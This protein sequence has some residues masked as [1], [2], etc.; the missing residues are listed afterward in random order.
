MSEKRISPTIDTGI[1]RRI[2][3]DKISYVFTVACGMDINKKQIRKTTTWKPP[4][5]LTMRKADKKAKEEYVNFKNRC[6]GLT[7]F[8][9]NMKF[10]DLCEEYFKFYVPNNLKPIT[11]YN[12]KQMFNYRL[13]P[14]FGNKKLKDIN[15][16]M[17]TN[18]FCN[19]TK[20]TPEGEHIPLS[21]GTTK[22]IFNMMQSAFQFAIRQK[23]I[24]DNP[25]KGVE[26]PKYAPTHEDAR[27]YLN[28]EELPQFLNLF[29]KNRSDFDRIILLLLH[30]GMR[31]GELLGL[32]W[33]NIDFEHKQIFVKHTLSSVG[34]KHL[35]T[36]PKTP[37]S[38]RVI[39]MNSTVYD[40]FLI[41]QKYQ[42]EMIQC[43]DSFAH[44]EMV[45]TSPH[46]NYKDRSNL[47]TSFKKFL[48]G[49]E[50]EFMTL[51]C[52]RHSN[53]TLLLNSGIDLK[54]VSEHLGHSNVNTTGNIYTAILV[55]SKQKTAEIIELKLTN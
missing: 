35:L 31:S 34:G 39:A 50:F 22:R 42:F 41:Q 6:L 2:S 18:Y 16:T 38:N 29:D 9:E 36:T 46:G 43:L 30:T 33:D 12:Y 45:F 20:E 51:H 10:K 14:F 24:K 28:E 48:I 1:V 8:N 5:E 47:N 44:P 25:C 54:I 53:A 15:T 17:L 32:S 40:L 7:S 49:S 21:P 19:L 11:A 23:I 13:I 52:L 27:K 26:L 3:G 55:S 37:S 4:A